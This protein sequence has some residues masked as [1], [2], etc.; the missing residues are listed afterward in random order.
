MVRR[1]LQKALK[2]NHKTLPGM[3][4]SDGWGHRIDPPDYWMNLDRRRGNS[5]N[6]HASFADQGLLYHW[7]K[8]VK[9]NVSIIIYDALWSSGRRHP[10][11]VP[12]TRVS[13]WNRTCQH[14]TCMDLAL[15]APGDNEKVILG[16]RMLISGITWGMGNPGK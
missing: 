16:I 13:C 8:Y 12:S 7:V 6:F 9:K 11:K 1:V 4:I 14:P 15:M 10:W 5:W 2:Y 3:F